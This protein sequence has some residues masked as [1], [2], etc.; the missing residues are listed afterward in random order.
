MLNVKCGSRRRGPGRTRTQTGT[1]CGALG[2]FWEEGGQSLRATY[3]FAE[4]NTVKRESKVQN[5]VVERAALYA[6]HSCLCAHRL[7]LGGAASVLYLGARASTAWSQE[8]FQGGWP[9]PRVAGGQVA[10]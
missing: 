2:L 9:T 7:P 8:Q 6:K 1:N 10:Y 4:S 5:G 3:A